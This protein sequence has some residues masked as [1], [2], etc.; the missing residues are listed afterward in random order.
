MLELVRPF[1]ICIST[2]RNLLLLARCL[3]CTLTARASIY[4]DF[5]FL[6][7]ARLRKL[8]NAK[9]PRPEAK[10]A[11]KEDGAAE[12][13]DAAEDAE[14]GEADS[15]GDSAGDSEDGAAGDSGSDG[16]AE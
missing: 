1:F 15:D 9:G 5:S 13:D 6:D 10:A 7:G 12:D 14:R 3:C 16:P 4:H 11:R 2:T 8:S